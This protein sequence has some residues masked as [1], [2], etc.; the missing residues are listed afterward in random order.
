[1]P[2]SGVIGSAVSFSMLAPE[3]LAVVGI[4]VREGFSEA[5]LSR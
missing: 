3:I 1:M 5:T 2:E 4:T